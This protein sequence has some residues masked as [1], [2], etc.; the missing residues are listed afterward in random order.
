MSSDLHDTSFQHLRS[1]STLKIDK[2]CVFF[3]LDSAIILPQTEFPFRWGDRLNIILLKYAVGEKVIHQLQL[4]GSLCGIGARQCSPSGTF[5]MSSLLTNQRT[6]LFQILVIYQD[7]ISLQ[8]VLR[9]RKT[10]DQKCVIWTVK[11]NGK[12]L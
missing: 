8:Y 4:S 10:N 2:N 6:D 3:C 1:G 9:K 7:M 5:V 11:P 12:P